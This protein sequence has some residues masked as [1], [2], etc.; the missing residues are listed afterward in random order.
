MKFKM[1]LFVLLLVVIAGSSLAGYSKYPYREEYS[2]VPTIETAALFAA[3][4]AGEV[5]VVDVRSPL[6]YEV[7]HVESAAHAAVSGDGFEEKLAALSA[8][9]PGKKLVFYCNGTTCLKAYKATERALNSGYANSFAYDSGIPEWSTTH[10]EKTI[11]LGK[12]VV[13]PKTQLIKKSDFEKKC[14]AWSTFKVLGKL[15]KAIVVDVRDEYQ[16]AGVLPGLD[17]ALDIPLAEFI[18]DVVSQK[19]YQDKTLLIFDQVGKQV[20]WLQYYL[21]DNGY[22]DFIFLKNGATGVLKDQ[23]YSS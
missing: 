5:L 19:K 14:M 8:K 20:R 10:P 9:N 13:D 15:D 18:S 17:K 22:N 11:L 1:P 21:K 23:G 7:I 16:K 3:I 6:E 2:H 4:N 12:T